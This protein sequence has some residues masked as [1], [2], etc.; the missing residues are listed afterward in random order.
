MFKKTKSIFKFLFQSNE[1][2][3]QIRVLVSTIKDYNQRLTDL[4]S[5]MEDMIPQIAANMAR[6]I[7]YS[8]I[9]VSYV[10]LGHQLDY[11]ELS[12]HIDFTQIEPD[13]DYSDLAD[14]VEY[15]KLANETDIPFLAEKINLRYLAQEVDLDEIES[16]INYTALGE[17]VSKHQL[18]EATL[19]AIH[20]FNT[21]VDKC[22]EEIEVWKP[23]S[24]FHEFRKLESKVLAPQ[25]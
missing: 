5:K 24:L 21:K 7:D 16:R 4:D 15:N 3:E 23:L 14:E 17:S 6:H 8:K 11:Q 1:I 2:M 10:N 22:L 13:F 18:A 20:D 9:K 25:T 12:K 19:T